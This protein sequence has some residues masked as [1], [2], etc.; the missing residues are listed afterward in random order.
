[1]HFTRSNDR[2]KKYEASLKTKIFSLKLDVEVINGNVQNKQL[3]YFRIQRNIPYT[4][5]AVCL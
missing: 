2:K 3:S 5:A 1:M 4:V